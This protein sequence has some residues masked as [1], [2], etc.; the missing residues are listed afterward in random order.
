MNSK[1]NRAD[2]LE[3]AGKLSS[4]ELELI[5]RFEDWLPNEIIDS[6]AHSNLE[7]HVISIDSRA[8]NHMLSTFPSFSIDES[9]IWHKLFHPGKKIR[10]LRFAKTF[11][12]INHKAAN[13]YLLEQSSSKDRVAL[14][15]IP[16]DIDYTV[17]M[18]RHRRVSALKMYYSYLEPP[19]T[20]IYQYFPTEVL[21]AVE[22]LDIPIILHP[23]SRITLCLSQ[24]LKLVN[25]FPKLRITLAHLSLTKSVVPGLEEAFREL[26]RFQNIHFDTSLVP[27]S[28]VVSLALRIVGPHKIMFGSDEPL[29]LI[30]SVPF[31]H[32][33]KGERLATAYPY[34][35]IDEDDFKTYKHL[36]LDATHSHWQALEAIRIS[37]SNFPTT[38]QGKIKEMIFH[39]N[40]CNFYG[41]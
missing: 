32:P 41:F 23:P 10:S 19:A 29:N 27:S 28:E 14:Y 18:L 21:E 33:E 2:Y 20:E 15:G 31:I 30:R 6:H 11:R 34:H 35:W 38:E 26:A 7:E 17:G 4:K 40:A 5:N 3:Y 37:V 9:K 24:I 13:L 25:D 16:S 22:E 39:D 8:F 12:G 36:A 1:I